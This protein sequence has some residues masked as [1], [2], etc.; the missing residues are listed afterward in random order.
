[1]QRLVN[2]P[3]NYVDEMLEG[4]YKSA[5]ND[6]CFVANDKRCYVTKHKKQVRLRSL[7]AEDQDIFLCSWDMSEKD[8]LTDAA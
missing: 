1:M 5:P 6:V 4:I 2:D 7:L 3:V 8:C